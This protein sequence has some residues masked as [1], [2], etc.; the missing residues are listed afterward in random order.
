MQLLIG[1]RYSPRASGCSSSARS[2]L[3]GGPGAV[4]CG[5][6]GLG[7][8]IVR[9]I[10]ER[11]GG[12]VSVSSEPDAPTVFMIWLPAAGFVSRDRVNATR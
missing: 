10:V 8:S 4:W 2:F 12:T 3:Q 5:G 11:H 1:Q 7:L 6:S 9:A